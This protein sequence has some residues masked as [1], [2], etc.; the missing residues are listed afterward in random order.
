MGGLKRRWPGESNLGSKRGS[1][2]QSTNGI[3]NVRSGAM[4]HGSGVEPVA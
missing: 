1:V 2:E 4:N 3:I